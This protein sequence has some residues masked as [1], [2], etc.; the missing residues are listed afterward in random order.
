VVWVLDVAPALPRVAIDRSHIQK[1]IINHTP[2]AIPAIHADRPA[3]RLEIAARRGSTGDGRPTVRIT[4][5]DDGPGVAAFD[6]S[7]LFVPFFSTKAPGQGTGLGLSVSFDI[8]RRHDG[9]LSYE[10]AP[11]GRGARFIV[12]LPVEAPSSARAQPS[13][14]RT[15]PA[16]QARR[17]PAGARDRAVT[18]R[19]PGARRPRALILD[20]E[21]SIRTFLRKA[22]TAAGFEAVVAADGQTAV[23][24]VRA[25]PIDVAL[26]DHRMPGMTGIEAFEEAVAARPELAGRWLFMSGD[27]LN[28]DLQA[29]AEARGLPLLAKPFDLATVNRAVGEIVERLGLVD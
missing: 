7:K 9:T 10:P 23:S 26:V 25:G 3:G 24:A 11:G 6:R 16:R 5:T 12:D 27:V 22:L 13:P 29:F 28:P 21:E 14:T 15:R 8:V 18:G 19:A 2:N 4:V 17:S 20:D 1:V